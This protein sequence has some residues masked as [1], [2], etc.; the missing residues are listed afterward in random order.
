M[1][2]GGRTLSTARL[3]KGLSVNRGRPDLAALRRETDA[4]R[5]V[6]GVLPHAARS[7]A[8]S[9]VV[10]PEAQARATAVAYLYC[11]MLDTYEDLLPDPD[12][13]VEEMNRFAARFRQPEPE[14]ARAIPAAL[15]RDERDRVYLLLI[16]RCDLVDQVFASLDP[17]ARDQVAD[18]V[19]SMATGMAWARQAFAEQGGVLVDEDQLATYCR[20]V[21]G[22]PALFTLSRVSDLQLPDPAREDALLVSEMI[23]LA[24]VTRDVERDLE[25]GVGYHPD[26]KPY[27]GTRPEGAAAKGAV[28]EARE[29]YMAMALARVPAYRRLFEG[30]KLGGSPSTRFAAVLMLLFTELHYRGCAVRTG[31]PAWPGPRGRLDVVLRSL[32]A[33]ISPSWAVHTIR[34]VER[35]FLASLRTLEPAL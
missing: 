31:N 18:L 7:F 1:R 20:S 29:A 8:A 34:R 16:D 4:E 24:N 32:P 26:L 23:Q 19:E 21:I 3:L 14:P 15:A 5:F 13:S 2:R 33:T 22:Y 11:R 10:L 27:L 30:M 17:E 6:W 9:I 25:R 12:Q 35:E 28:R